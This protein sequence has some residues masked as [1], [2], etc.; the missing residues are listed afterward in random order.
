MLTGGP[1]FIP[2]QVVVLESHAL[3]R[4]LAKGQHGYM[5]VHFWFSCGIMERP[6][7]IV[8]L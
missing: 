1:Q 4:L 6:L 3:Q 2:P 7:I 5:K 8:F